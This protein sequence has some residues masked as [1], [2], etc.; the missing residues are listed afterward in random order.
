MK[1]TTAERYLR[2]L[3]AERKHAMRQAAL[4]TKL[5]A[6][7]IK[8]AVLRFQREIEA[9][10]VAIRVL[11]GDRCMAFAGTPT[12]AIFEAEIRAIRRRLGT[13]E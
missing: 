2:G 4:H 1:F 13:T 5:T 12:E 6:G 11:E 9:L 7:E 3:K 10:D 8:S